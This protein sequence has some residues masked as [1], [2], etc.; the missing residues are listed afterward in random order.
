MQV[1][2][3]VLFGFVALVGLLTAGNAALWLIVP[4]RA[5]EALK[6]PLLTG[7]ALS[8]QM[9]IGAFFLSGAIFTGLALITR[10]RPWFI[11]AAVLVLGAAL[12][13]TAAFALHGAP[14]LADMVGAEL[15]MGSVMIIAA[16]V[17]GRGGN[18]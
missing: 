3:S 13:R 10:E 1:G 14:F 12:Y 17:L 18:G 15:V 16:R 6:M 11:A 5:A 7:A 8:T 2:R 9:D 4:E